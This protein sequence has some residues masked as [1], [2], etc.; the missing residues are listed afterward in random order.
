MAWI[1]PVKGDEMRIRML[2]VVMAAAL[3]TAACGGSDGDSGTGG[4]SGSSAG[5]ADE[6]ATLRFSF[7][8]PAGSNY[9]PATTTN[10]FVNVYLYPVYDR[11]VDVTPEGELQP[12]LAE[13]WEF[14]DDDRTLRLTLR[15]GVVF[16]DGTPF[17]AE[18]VKANIDRAKSLPNSS[19]KADLAAVS[20]VVVVDERTVDLRLG[21]PAGSLP[22]LLA[23]RA[24]MMV[25]P[26]AFGNP[27]LD[28]QPVGTG[29][30]RVTE[31]QPGVVIRYERSADYWAPDV[32][33]LGGLEIQ[34]Q[35]D[36]EVRLRSVSGGQA[37]A[38]QLNPDQV[39]A[40]EGPGVTVDSAPSLGSFT[41][42]LNK[43]GPALSDQRVR[44]AISLAID[45]Q[46]ISDALQ[47]GRCT[48]SAQLFPE[49]YWAHNPDIEAPEYDPD[50]ARELLAEAGQSDLSLNAVVINVPFYTAQL[51]AIQAQLAEVGV[52]LTVTSLEPTELL[53]RF[54]GG[55]ADMYFSNWPGA[56]DPAK[57]V[58]TLL[59]AQGTLNPGGYTNPEIDRLALEGLSATT[60]ED[61]AP[62]Y[63][64]LSEVMVEDATQIVVCNAT[65]TFVHTEQ[66]SGLESTLTGLFDFRGVT[67]SA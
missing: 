24:G 30:Y 22:A 29:P 16:H 49:D 2:S 9:D 53:S 48:P 14:T 7:G 13:S 59:S 4:G 15:E 62:A 67:V 58:A 39:E 66:V 65:N 33:T 57:T 40:A 35:L 50:R 51:E 21:A 19:L 34:M 37:D 31:H 55:E 45:R 26:A 41:L 27:D 1:T 11:L 42:F 5:P 47:A 64:E 36:P 20:E 52:D 56:T 23:D 8:T 10:Q 54:V 32:Q 43:S 63:Q 12:M 18:A 3:V 38:T 25:S 60:Q 17:D 44:E 6:D 61:R 28:L 46:G